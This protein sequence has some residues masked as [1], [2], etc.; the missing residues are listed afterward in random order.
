MRSGEFNLGVH[1]EELKGLRNAAYGARGVSSEAKVAP[2]V[3]SSSCWASRENT[4][5]YVENFL[6]L[7]L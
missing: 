2:F 7:I 6:S 5:R 1:M 3:I 4:Q